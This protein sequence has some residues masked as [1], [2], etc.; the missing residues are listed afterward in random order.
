VGA[1]GRTGALELAQN[2]F[3]REALGVTW[4]VSGR[5]WAQVGASGRRWPLVALVALVGARGAS[6]ATRV[7]CGQVCRLWASGR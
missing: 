3:R 7:P 2:P 4:G 6:G 5:R 1:S